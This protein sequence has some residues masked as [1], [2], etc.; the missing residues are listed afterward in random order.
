M[1]RH[2][3]LLADIGTH[4]SQINDA[5]ENN[6]KEA[7]FSVSEQGEKQSNLLYK[8]ASTIRKELTG[9]KDDIIK[10]MITNKK[11]SDSSISKLE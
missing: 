5:I 7:L 9:I 2:N 4:I 6:K 10:S 8:E 1:E 3:K 11:T